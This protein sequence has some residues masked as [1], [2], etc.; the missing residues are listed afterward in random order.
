MTSAPLPAPYHQFLTVISD[1]D[2][3][4]F[5]DMF[6]ERGSVNDWGHRYVGRD[7]IKTWSD[8]EFLGVHMTLAVDKAVDVDGRITIT[9]QVGGGGFNGPSTFVLVTE[10]DRLREMLITA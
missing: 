1:G 8:R 5:L 7:A 3:P 6:T 10:G 4:A 9:G 2:T